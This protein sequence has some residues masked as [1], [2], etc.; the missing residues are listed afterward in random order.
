M[1]GPHRVVVEAPR[2]SHPRGRAGEGAAQGRGPA[3]Q[4]G[5][6]LPQLA[7]QGV[8]RELAVP[9]GGGAGGR[10]GRP[11]P[12]RPPPPPPPPGGTGRRP[13]GG[14]RR[15]RPP[16]PPPPPRLPRRRPRRRRPR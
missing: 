6:Q 4:V 14:G 16:S 5:R 9:A 7:A 12:P 13:G 10:R 15:T 1:G 11:P 2:Q 3:P 8:L